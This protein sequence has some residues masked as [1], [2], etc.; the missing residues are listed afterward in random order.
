[1]TSTGDHDAED[2]ISP[3]ESNHQNSLHELSGRSSSYAPTCI[4]IFSHALPIKC[5][6][7]GILGCNPLMSQKICID[8]SSVTVLQHSWKTGWQIKKLND[9]A[10]LRL[11]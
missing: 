11:L 2:E 3:Q 4:G 9:T 8:D 5:L 7:T 1:M 10:H 6:L